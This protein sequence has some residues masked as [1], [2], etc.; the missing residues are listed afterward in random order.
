MLITAIVVNYNQR[1]HTRSC[2]ES[3]R[4]ALALVEGDTEVIVVDNASADGS[5][6]MVRGCFPEVTLISL[7]CNVGFAGA[8]RRAIDSSDSRWALLLN[9]DATIAQDALP[10]MLEAG[11]QD[12]RVGSV[13]A[14]VL[15]A[16]GRGLINSAG[17]GVDLLG[18]AFDRLVGAP[19]V[20]ADQFAH[21]VF[22]ASAAAALFRRR[23]LE[24]I[25]GFDERFFLY[26]EDADVAWRARSRGWNSLLVP[27][28]IVYH[29]HSASS[30][31]GSDFKYFHVG[32]NRVLMLAKNAPS[33]HLLRFGLPILAYD[34][35]YV[36]FVVA[37]DHSL[38][39][40]RGRWSGMRAWRRGRKTS[41]SQAVDHLES[42]RGLS[43]ALARRSAWR[44]S[45]AG[46][47]PS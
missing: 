32:R 3:L 42:I 31:H 11:E 39:P 26:L 40:L 35:A 37:T 14:L 6:E 19:A 21:P 8:I 2:L 7:E 18:V 45:S 5:I 47:P 36:A 30:Q 16:D 1:E 9:N 23:M 24:D 17:I 20:A 33:S 12:D 10:R 27:R 22:G 29:H 38:A 34:L 41:R 43:A 44:I 15:F 25:G 46:P 4:S 28:A 13:A